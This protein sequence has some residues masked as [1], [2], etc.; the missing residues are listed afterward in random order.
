[1]S[2]SHWWCYW[3][4]SKILSKPHRTRRGWLS[5]YHWC[6]SCC[7]HKNFKAPH[8]LKFITLTGKYRISYWSYFKF[9]IACS[10]MDFM[11]EGGRSRT[12]GIGTG[13]LWEN[14]HWTQHKSL[15]E[16]HRFFYSVHCP[17]LSQYEHFDIPRMPYFRYDLLFSSFLK[18]FSMISL[19]N[20]FLFIVTLQ[21]IHIM[22]W[23]TFMLRPKF[24]N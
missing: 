9:H 20:T 21:L 8:L 6:S 11:F 3:S 15:H 16:S 22:H 17:K 14:S 13:A 24:G 7:S 12:S 10:K 2:R 19:N 18:V 5:C 1:M 4:D 23:E